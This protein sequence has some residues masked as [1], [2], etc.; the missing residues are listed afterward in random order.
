MQ[1]DVFLR[2]ETQE[3][4]VPAGAVVQKAAER[5]EEPGWSGQT[6]G[7]G[8]IGL[9]G[10]LE[11]GHQRQVPQPARCFFDVWFQVIEGVLIFPVT[12]TRQ[13]SEVLCPRARVALPER[14]QLSL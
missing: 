4:L 8:W 12:G 10:F 13:T 6:D 5:I 11:P 14:P 3:V 9:A 2:F 7:C 1:G